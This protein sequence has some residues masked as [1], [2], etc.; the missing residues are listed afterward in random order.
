M[1]TTKVESFIK[2][3][4]KIGEF[5][6][7][8]SKDNSV[9]SP[10]WVIVEKEVSDH[11]R[12]IRFLILMGIVVLTCMGSLYS[13]LTN[14]AD[15]VEKSTDDFFFLKLFTTTDGVMPSFM[16]FISFLGPILGI[17][18]GFDAINS[19]QNSGT[20]SR[21]MSQPIHR[22]NFL[23]A[24]FLA[25]LIV[26]AILFFSLGFLVIG[27]GLYFIGIP[28]TAEEFFRFFFFTVVSVLY[29]AFWLNLSILFSVRFRQTSTSAL[30]GIGVWLFFTVFYTL[31]VNLIANAIAPAQFAPAQQ[32]ANYER[33]VQN[34]LSVIP[35]QMY[36][37]ATTTLL[38]PSVRSLSPL[39]MEELSRALPNPISLGQSLLVVWPQLTGL[40]AS[41]ILC[42]AFT[43]MMFMRREIRSK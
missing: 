18:L 42:F 26:V 40:I 1:S 13:S 8:P 22:D 17:G 12:S 37:D 34:L 7:K 24:K 35:S 4:L 14:F 15:V 27:F 28:P 21:V 43:Y 39:T 11:F 36:T 23:N 3:N 6:R 19:E 16:V 32:I 41:A 30:A 2:S 33:F 5:F 20:L 9:K 29:V 38:M 31:I 25:G 10:F